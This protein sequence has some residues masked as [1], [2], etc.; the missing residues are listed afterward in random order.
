MAIVLLVFSLPFIGM[1]N[2]LLFLSGL[3]VVPILFVLLWQPGAPQV[4]LFAALFQWTQ[5]FVDIINH[6]HLYTITGLSTLDDAIALSF[7]ALVVLALGIRLGIE[8]AELDIRTKLDQ[9][10]KTRA[11]GLFVGYLI[12]IV[13][14]QTSDLLVGVVP[15]LRQLL[16][17]I[18]DFRWIFVILIFWGA[19]RSSRF[20]PYAA[21]VL[22]AELLV[23]FLSYFS[24]FKLVLFA[25]IVTLLGKHRSLRA[26]FNSR[27]LVITSVLLVLVGFWQVVK[28]D[29]RE[30]LSQGRLAQVELISVTERLSFLSSRISS[31][32][33]EDIQDGFDK[34][35]MRIGYTR[36][37]AYSIRQVPAK[38]DYQNGKLWGEAVQHV[39]MPRAF[40]PGKKAVNDSERTQT[41]TGIYVAGIERGT[42]ISIGYVGESYIDFGPVFMFVPIFFLGVFWGLAYRGLV[43]FP[44]CGYL[45][46]ATGITLILHHAILFESSNIKLLG[47]AVT[48][49][50]VFIATLY[51][52]RAR[53]HRFLFG[54]RW[55]AVVGSS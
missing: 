45:G 16:L 50:I 55:R 30:H 53:I 20:L 48:A 40:F 6:D 27:L 15:P 1:D 46:A 24:S 36:Y 38:I 13:A 37:F 9:V 54:A 44:G 49:F 11:S 29:Y 26:L 12:A 41:Y 18:S 28:E 10:L 23:G 2:Y 14:G 5:V 34:G 7:V 32:T 19:V 31:I 8:N 35:L 21:V 33:S 3:L 25:A 22:G 39:F 43:N 51:F 4:L 42:S 17:V 52:A 47:G